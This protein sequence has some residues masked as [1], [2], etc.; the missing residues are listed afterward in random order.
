MEPNQL[1]SFEAVYDL[2]LYSTTLNHIDMNIVGRTSLII[3]FEGE[4]LE[5]HELVLCSLV[6]GEVSTAMEV[7]P[8]NLI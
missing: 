1:Q 2:N 6:L 7:L 5:A 4:D 8:S 3:H